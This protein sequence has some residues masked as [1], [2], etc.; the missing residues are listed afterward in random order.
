MGKYTLVEKRISKRPFKKIC[1]SR[2]I[3]VFG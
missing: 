3:E 2:E 1:Y